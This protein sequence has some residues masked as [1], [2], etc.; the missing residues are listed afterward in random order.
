[1]KITRLAV[2]GLMLLGL[3]ACSGGGSSPLPATPSSQS[4]ARTKL[5]TFGGTQGPASGYAA[6][7]PDP[8]GTMPIYQ[9]GQ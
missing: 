5:D 8:I 9:S 7:K 2:A 1:M 6:L 4:V 3:A